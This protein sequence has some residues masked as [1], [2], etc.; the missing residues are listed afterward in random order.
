MLGGLIRKGKQQGAN[1]VHF[2]EGALSGYTKE[3]FAKDLQ[4]T[5]SRSQFISYVVKLYKNENPLQ[6]D[7]DRNILKFSLAKMKGTAEYTDY[8]DIS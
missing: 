3:Q 8:V 5:K 2:C 7:V 4:A 6:R 1:I